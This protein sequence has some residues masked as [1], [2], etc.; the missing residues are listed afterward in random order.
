MTKSAR[1]LKLDIGKPYE[2][3]LESGAVKVIIVHGSSARADGGSV[4]HI[5]V[6]GVQGVYATVDGALGGNYI[7]VVPQAD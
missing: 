6:D 5:S 2:F 4:L 3:T 1:T 7:A